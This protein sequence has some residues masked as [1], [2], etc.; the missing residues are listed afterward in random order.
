MAGRSS[1]VSKAISCL[2][3]LFLLAV[4]FTHHDLACH[5]KTPFHCTA[6]MSSPP[7]SSPEAP[8]A[9]A[10][11]Q[12]FDAG[13]AVSCPPL[14]D[15]ALLVVPSIG[16]SPPRAHSDGCPRQAGLSS[17]SFGSF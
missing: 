8:A 10:A 17:T 6:C 4:P 16:R 12:L 1:A 5:L 11:V 14:A 15:G 13:S 9:A 7:G 3:A 2:Y